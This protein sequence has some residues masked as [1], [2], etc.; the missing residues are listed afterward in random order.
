M[1]NKKNHSFTN[2]FL[3]KANNSIIQNQKDSA[4]KDANRSKNSFI[5]MNH[6]YYNNTNKE[7]EPYS[8]LV[9]PPMKK[10]TMN[11]NEFST[12][13]NNFRDNLD[14]IKERRRSSFSSN[15]ESKASWVKLKSKI[16][17]GKI[18][19]LS[20]ATR[21]KSQ[22]PSM[23][24]LGADKEKVKSTTG[25]TNLSMLGAESQSPTCLRNN[26]LISPSAFSNLF[27]EDRDNFR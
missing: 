7:V 14:E 15:L 26:L 23:K 4:H 3:A 20:L 21:N 2:N 18:S 16:P 25:F 1:N 24:G 11:H 12:K 9:L 17:N 22:I 8:K 5:L 27:K 19:N 10:E 13:S 6:S